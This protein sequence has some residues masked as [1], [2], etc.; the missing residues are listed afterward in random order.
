MHHNTKKRIFPRTV[1]IYMRGADLEL[2]LGLIVSAFLKLGGAFK[3]D[4]PRLNEPE[5]KRKREKL[6]FFCVS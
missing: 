6:E 5:N 3:L 1:D 4:S 2:G